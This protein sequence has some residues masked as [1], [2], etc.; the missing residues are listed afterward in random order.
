MKP[1]T[2][3]LQYIGV[4]NRGTDLYSGCLIIIQAP[5]EQ[6]DYSKKRIQDADLL[7]NYSKSAAYVHIW[8]TIFKVTVFSC[9]LQREL[10]Q[11]QTKLMNNKQKAS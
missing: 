11:L 8:H 3:W 9:M 2:E 10:H 1:S 6:K 5:K 7:Q 4:P